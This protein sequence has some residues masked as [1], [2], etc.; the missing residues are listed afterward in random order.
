MGAGIAQLCLEAGIDTVGREVTTELG[1]R[2][3]E[4][5]GRVEIVRAQRSAD[6]AVET[7]S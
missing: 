6:E 5:I 3:A 4:R 7:A 2:A 1:E